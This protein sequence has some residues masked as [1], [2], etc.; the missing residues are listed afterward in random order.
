MSLQV[1]IVV[2]SISWWI[3]WGT[4]CRSE[5][6]S[7]SMKI[8]PSF[9]RWW[10][11]SHTL[12][13][14]PLPIGFIIIAPN[15]F[16]KRTNNRVREKEE[17]D[18]QMTHCCRLGL[19]VCKSLQKKS[20]TQSDTAGDENGLN[21]ED[22]R[23]QVCKGS[24]TVFVMGQDKGSW[25]CTNMVETIKLPKTRFSL[26]PVYTYQVVGLGRVSWDGWRVVEEEPGS[27]PEIS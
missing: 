23:H 7:T 25:H 3:S 17:K 20:R 11:T 13:L 27:T 14:L 10:K 5:R 22:E 15:F 2:L 1:D 6:T 8:E 26:L 24:K 12:L 19:F 18:T 9:V 16:K 4:R 21:K